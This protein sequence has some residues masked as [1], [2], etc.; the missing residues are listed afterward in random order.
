[1]A[2]DRETISTEN[3]RTEILILNALLYREKFCRKAIVYIQP[4]YFDQAPERILFESISFLF[5]KHSKVPSLDM[6][7]VYLNNRSDVAEDVYRRIREYIPFLRSPLKIPSGEWLLETT[8]EWCQDRAFFNATL[9]AAQVLEKSDKK[10]IS[11][12]EIPEL[13]K[14]ALAVSFDPNIGH[15]YFAD[16]SERFDQY[17]DPGER[18]PFGIEM[19][20]RVTNG[21][22]KRKTITVFLAP[23]N[24]GKTLFMC[25]FAAS[26]IKSGR[27]VL[28]LSLEMSEVEIARRIDSNLLQMESDKIEKLPKEKYISRI[29][30]MRNL[31]KGELVIKQYPTG[32]A[33]VNHFRHLL[34]EL[35]LKKNFVPDVLYVDYLNLMASAAYPKGAE[36]YTRVK[37]CIEE[38]RGL[39]VEH[40]LALFTA[41]QTNRSGFDAIDLDMDDVS[42]S[43]GVPATADYMFGLIQNED[44]AETGQMLIRVIKLRYDGKRDFPRFLVGVDTPK[45]TIYDIR[46]EDQKFSK[47]QE[48]EEPDDSPAF[49]RTKFGTRLKEERSIKF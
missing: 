26:A 1:M 2:N 37:A 40:D 10:K 46:E 35:R 15:D 9:N 42:E 31:I 16:L 48:E 3:D 23:P 38:I 32:V 28:Y 12:G 44:L 14:Q 39:A 20:D 49:D 5:N 4:E 30:T 24:R 8:E 41:T 13:F 45:M 33:N 7:L 29:Q 36:S 18:I 22:V 6:L 11:K 34:Q 21:G 27:N 43:F 47:K 19:F 25:N 17:Q